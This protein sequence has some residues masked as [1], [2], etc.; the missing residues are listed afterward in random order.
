MSLLGNAAHGYRSDSVSYQPDLG[1]N[2]SGGFS[3]YV[4]LAT[5][6]CSLRNEALSLSPA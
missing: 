6:A 2:P 4:A 1:S 5:L 3:A